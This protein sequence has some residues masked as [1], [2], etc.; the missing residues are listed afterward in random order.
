V[1]GSG[2]SNASNAATAS[3][4]TGTGLTL[5]IKGLQAFDGLIDSNDCDGSGMELSTYNMKVTKNVV[6]NFFFGGGLTIDQGA[7]NFEVIGNRVHDS[8]GSDI[9]GTF[10]S[11]IENWGER[12]VVSGNICY[13]NSSA[14]ISH[15]GQ[16]CIE[17]HLL[18]QWR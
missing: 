16:R 10:P 3:G 5:D 17:Q 1:P 11:G 18:R 4:S 13:N 6:R 14:G 2:Y 15:G 12:S 9:T 8:S 7:Y